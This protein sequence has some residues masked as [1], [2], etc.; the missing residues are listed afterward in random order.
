MAKIAGKNKIA[1]LESIDGCEGG[2]VSFMAVPYFSELGPVRKY[3]PLAEIDVTGDPG[4]GAILERDGVHFINSCLFSPD[5]ETLENMDENFKDLVNSV[6][7]PQA[8]EPLRFIRKQ[9]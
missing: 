8:G 1:E 4:K 2:Y 5:T 7:K 9:V 6:V 3:L